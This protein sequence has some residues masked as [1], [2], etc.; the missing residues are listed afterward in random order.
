M[1]P[2]C[3]RTNTAAQI[4][5]NCHP[6]G[7]PLCCNATAQPLSYRANPPW[8]QRRQRAVSV[9]A[10]VGRSACLDSRPLAGAV[11]MGFRFKHVFTLFSPPLDAS[12]PG[13]IAIVTKISALGQGCGVD[14][15]SMTARSVPARRHLGWAWVARRRIDNIYSNS[16][17]LL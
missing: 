2:A 1:L 16:M 7:P 15:C 5:S 9:R 14:I 8:E 13:P 12:L 4:V 3:I 17:S 10:E 11:R 6:R